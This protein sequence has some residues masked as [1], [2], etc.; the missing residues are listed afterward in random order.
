MS[1]RSYAAAE[2]T[3]TDAAHSQERQDNTER[4]EKTAANLRYGQAISEQGIGGKTT[5]ANG[6]ANQG[7]QH[8]EGEAMVDMLS[9][10]LTTLGPDGF[11]GTDAQPED[12]QATETRQEQGYGSG[13]GVGA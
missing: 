9:W 3:R 6:A 12:N 13:S 1:G 2:E 11:G 7:S 10:L 4:G 8:H 5:E